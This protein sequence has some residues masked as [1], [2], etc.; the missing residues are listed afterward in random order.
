[1]RANGEMINAVGSIWTLD[2]RGVASIL[3]WKNTGK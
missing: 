3:D 1:M 2:R